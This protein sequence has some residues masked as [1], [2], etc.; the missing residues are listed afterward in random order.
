MVGL[1]LLL[2]GAGVSEPGRR[3]SASKANGALQ[4]CV[5]LLEQ[6]GAPFVTSVREI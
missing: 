1:L 4:P 2:E 5:L 3:C 6:L